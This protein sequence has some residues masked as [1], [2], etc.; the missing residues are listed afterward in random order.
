MELCFVFILH[1]MHAYL[2]SY[3]VKPKIALMQFNVKRRK[4]IMY[5]VLLI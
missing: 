1:T 5:Y 4:T 3:F 2:Q